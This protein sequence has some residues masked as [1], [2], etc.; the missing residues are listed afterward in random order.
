MPKHTDPAEAK[1][2][3]TF[4]SLAKV[5]LDESCELF[6]EQASKLGFRQYDS[7][8]GRNTPEI[9][10]KNIAL[11]ER[12]LDGVE[13]LPEA[14]FHGDDWLDRRGLLA[15]LRMDLLSE[16][17]LLRWRTNPQTH[18]NSAIDAIFE[19]VVRNSGKLRQ[20]LPAIE[21]R[22]KKIPA[23]LRAGAECVEAPDPLWTSLGVQSCAGAVEFLHGLEKELC[24]FSNKPK[25]LASTLKSAAKAFEEYAADITR[26][27]PGPK[28]GFAIGRARFEFLIRENLGLDLSLPEARALG[29]Y[30]I[31]RHEVLL[32]RAARRH[33]RKSAREII[34]QAAADWTP[35]LPLLEVY[36]EATT[37]IK[38]RLQKLGLVTVPTGDT[39]KVLPVPPFLKHQ[40]PTAA[41]SAPEPFAKDQAGIFWVNDLSL[42]QKNPEKKLAEI[43][44]HHGL[45]LTTVH[46]AYP[47]H[48]L[49]FVVQFQHASRLRRLFA[50]SIFYEGWTMWCEKLAVEHGLVDMPGAELI[51]LHDALW[52]AHRIVI[53]CGLHDGALSHAAA[54]K[55][56]QSG[57]G[58]TSARAAADVNWYTSSPTVPMSYL[59]GRLEVEKL[60]R[61]L[62]R[63]SGWPLRKF[64][65]WMLSHGAIP[66]SWIHRV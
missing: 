23:Y 55:R 5:W 32:E 29:E 35:G 14:A 9:H 46:E 16:R 45:E 25:A 50:H 58:F 40:F 54:S 33:G 53:D 11:L 24:S 6:P 38:A 19:L 18:S 56:L 48:H 21:S 30:Q 47:G 61:Q 3:A 1:I 57:V 63:E 37:N 62:V 17:D 41:Y 10:R 65:D 36:R 22:L 51:Q 4:A 49:Q 64:N 31:Q 28:G 2:R 43:R 59:L 13:A 66:Y 26:K 39:L 60:H 20:A 15:R 27:K 34:A 52:R 8:L 12:T 7:L 44:Q 42:D